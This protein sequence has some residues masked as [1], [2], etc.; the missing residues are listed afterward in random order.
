[1]SAPSGLEDTVNIILGQNRIFLVDKCTCTYLVIIKINADEK[2]F[3]Y[4]L[5]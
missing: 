5:K 2:F 1:M 4:T 3:I